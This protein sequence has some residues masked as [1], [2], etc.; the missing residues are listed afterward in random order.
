MRK[1]ERRQHD[2]ALRLASDQSDYS[3]LLW[4]GQPPISAHRA[5]EDRRRPRQGDLTCGVFGIAPRAQAICVSAKSDRMTCVHHTGSVA[6]GGAALLAARTGRRPAP[7]KLSVRHCANLVWSDLE[8][9]DKTSGGNL[10]QVSWLR[11]SRTDSLPQRAR[12]EFCPRV[13]S[14][15]REGVCEVGQASW[16]RR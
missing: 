6:Y 8:L 12:R 11:R 2:L 7:P 10:R 5:D 16:L 15:R 3:C 9:C 14:R 13:L 4:R 1:K